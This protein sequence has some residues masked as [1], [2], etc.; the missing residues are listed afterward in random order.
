MKQTEKWLG[1]L[2][3]QLIKRKNFIRNQ[4]AIDRTGKFWREI[5]EQSIKKIKI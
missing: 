4:R 2:N 5:N 1:E 3:G